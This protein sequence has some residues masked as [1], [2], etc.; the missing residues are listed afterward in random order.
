MLCWERAVV[1]TTRD[2]SKAL[3]TVNEPLTDTAFGFPGHGYITV[4]LAEEYTQLRH[5]QESTGCS[6]VQTFF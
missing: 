1:H 5:K 2:L 4:T 6:S 3:L